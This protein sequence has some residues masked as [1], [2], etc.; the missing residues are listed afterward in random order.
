M[1]VSFQYTEDEY[2]RACWM[3]TKGKLNPKFD[4]F[5]A[6]G[7]VV[8]GVWS[9]IEGNKYTGWGL[10]GLVA[11][12][13]GI[14]AISRYVVPKYVYRNS[15]L[16]KGEYNFD[17]SNEGIHYTSNKIDSQFQWSMFTKVVKGS[18]HFLIYYGRN[19]FIIIPKRAFKSAE[20]LELFNE[21]L[22]EHIPPMAAQ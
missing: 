4:A 18:E 10:L 11:V 19:Q 16:E 1:K 15:I 14:V 20:D 6:L 22:K 13:V 17:F 9:I 7:C 3:H 2:A 21:L 8:F 5:V 12:L